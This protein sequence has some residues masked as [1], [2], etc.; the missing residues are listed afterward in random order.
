MLITVELLE[1]Y[2]G[3]F[4]DSD[5]TQTE[6][7]EIY[8]KSAQA[9][10]IDYLGYNPETA[11]D[12]NGEPLVDEFALSKIKNVCLEIAALLAMEADNNL[13]VNTSSDAGG[14]SRS[15]LNVVDF[16]RYLAKLSAYRKNTGM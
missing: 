7:D 11:T 15:F 10:I 5:A 1:R 13:G 6:L 14:I 2:T 3:T 9:E 16:S 8:I 12:G 4:K